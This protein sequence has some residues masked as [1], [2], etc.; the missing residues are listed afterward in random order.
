MQVSVG[1]VVFRGEAAGIVLACVADGETLV[2]IVDVLSCAG[3]LSP[4]SA[5]WALASDEKSGWLRILSQQWVGTRS[6]VAQP[7]CSDIDRLHLVSG[8]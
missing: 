8:W 1:D 3:K 4:H 2:A 5:S 7:L 6:L